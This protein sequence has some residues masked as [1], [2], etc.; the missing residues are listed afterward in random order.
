[1]QV[2]ASACMEVTDAD[3]PDEDTVAMVVGGEGS[4]HYEV[5]C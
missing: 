4:E 5:V 1:M 3:M 2:I